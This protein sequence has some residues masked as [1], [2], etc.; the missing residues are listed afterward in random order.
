[1]G[2]SRGTPLRHGRRIYPWVPFLGAVALAVV[3]A[4]AWRMD[5]L[6]ALAVIVRGDRCLFAIAGKG[7]VIVGGVER[8][9]GGRYQAVFYDKQAQQL[10]VLGHVGRNVYRDGVLSLT[11][12][13]AIPTWAWWAWSAGD[14]PGST[15]DGQGG[16][17]PV[18][19][20]TQYVWRLV[21][22]CWPLFV[23][24]LALW[25]LLI[26][27]ARR[28]RV[29]P[30]ATS[31]RR[32]AWTAGLWAGS[33]VTVVLVLR[34]LATE[35]PRGFT[36]GA[37][38]TNKR[39]MVAEVR[40]GVLECSTIRRH[41]PGAYS[42]LRHVGD[43]YSV[44]GD[45]R[46]DGLLARLSQGDAGLAP[47]LGFRARSFAN[48]TLA[49]QFAGASPSTGWRAQAPHWA[50]YIVL[51]MLCAV[52]FAVPFM[53]WRRARIRTRTGL[54][55]LCGYDLRATPDRCPECGSV[56]ETKPQVNADAPSAASPGDF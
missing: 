39:V 13:L 49:P 54:C 30:A 11:G 43:H 20:P 23:A 16:F 21:I 12:D 51:G 31:R 17:K 36:A 2:T 35:P 4:L 53:R 18:Q 7:A 46:V 3:C 19:H 15:P 32:L 1:M 27:R 42:I 45:G 24:M 44:V 14:R 9:D 56:P 48:C 37:V 40:E 22:P 8:L 28:T 26:R 34:S 33:I 10:D 50:L 55:L 5:R 41:A 52:R 47:R 6:A 29:V 25:V 38:L